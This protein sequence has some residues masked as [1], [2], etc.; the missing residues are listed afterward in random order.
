MYTG[1]ELRKIL[2]N[3]NID[4]NLPISD[5]NIMDGA[6]VSGNVWTAGNDYILKSDSR[7]KLIKKL[8]IAK[9]LHEQGFVAALPVL[10]KTR[11]EYFEDQECFI[12]VRGLCDSPNG[13]K[14][15]NLQNTE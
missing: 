9:A 2:G 1:K 3:W 10:T 8:K 14:V 11:S 6:K 13:N 7:E 5:V 12:L 15:F 4:G